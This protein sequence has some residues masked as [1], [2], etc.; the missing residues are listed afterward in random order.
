MTDVPFLIK[1]SS[2]YLARRT[3]YTICCPW[4]RKCSSDQC[5]PRPTSSDLMGDKLTPSIQGALDTSY[6]DLLTLQ[7][8]SK[9]QDPGIWDPRA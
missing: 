6:S 4:G 9:E 3:Y 5:G 7:P 8:L 2:Q 1:N